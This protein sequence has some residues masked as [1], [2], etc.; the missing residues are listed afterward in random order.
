MG[1][2]KK[3]VCKSVKLESIEEDDFTI[4]PPLNEVVVDGRKARDRNYHSESILYT[5]NRRTNESRMQQQIT[6]EPPLNF[7]VYKVRKSLRE[8][9]EKEGGIGG[10]DA[11]NSFSSRTSSRQPPCSYIV[12]LS[13]TQNHKA[14]TSDGNT[15][16][17]TTGFPVCPSLVADLI[18]GDDAEEEQG[19]P[20]IRGS[21]SQKI[22]DEITMTEST[23]NNCFED[24]RPQT[25]SVE[26]RKPQTAPIDRQRPRTAS[27]ER[28]KPPPVSVER[29]KPPK[30]VDD[31][32]STSHD[33]DMYS[34]SINSESFYSK[35]MITESFYPNSVYTSDYSTMDDTSMDSVEMLVHHVLRSEENRSVARDWIT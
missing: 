13:H 27:F 32:Y 18:M 35:S 9:A 10:E 16:Y 26:R 29:R 1:L 15:G 25:A 34:D 28:R 14:K 17:C 19:R 33:S 24:Q 6:E 30:L 22:C 2:L 20:R 11:F 3:L 7:I 5:M 31:A 21:E 12:S 8:K 23:F 4:Y